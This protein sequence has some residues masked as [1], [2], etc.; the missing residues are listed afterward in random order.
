MQLVREPKFKPIP[1]KIYEL[2]MKAYNDPNYEGTIGELAD[3][4]EEAERLKEYTLKHYKKVLEYCG[5]HVCAYIALVVIDGSA[6]GQH[7]DEPA[8][9]YNMD[10]FP[11]GDPYR[12]IR[13]SEIRK[14]F[15]WL[16]P[17]FLGP[18]SLVKV[19]DYFFWQFERRVNF[20]GAV[21]WYH[22]FFGDNIAIWEGHVQF[23][24]FMREFDDLRRREPSGDV[25]VLALRALRR[26]YDQK[27]IRFLDVSNYYDYMRNPNLPMPKPGEAEA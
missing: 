6:P 3:N 14:A 24:E 21:T 11:F 27:R 9:L 5:K 8:T 22:D 10:W 12:V 23:A 26:L 4:P 7:P 2:M 20:A 1:K 16:N 25:E 17:M 13:I 19:H 15:D 18:Y